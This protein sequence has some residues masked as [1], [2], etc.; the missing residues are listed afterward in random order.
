MIHFMVLCE[1]HA[2][3]LASRLGPQ[4]FQS[5]LFRLQIAVLIVLD[6]TFAGSS[7]QDGSWLVAYE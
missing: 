3:G 6:A 1:L 4:V 7:W 5:T 2:L